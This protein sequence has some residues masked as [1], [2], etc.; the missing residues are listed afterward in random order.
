MQEECYWAEELLAD[1][2]SSKN[3]VGKIVV[4]KPQPLLSPAAKPAMAD[5]PTTAPQ[6]RAYLAS[7]L[8][9]YKRR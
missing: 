7:R 8:L 1:M 9:C 3:G 5:V 6:G 4:E 2:K